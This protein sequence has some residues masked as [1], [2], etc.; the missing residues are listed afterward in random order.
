MIKGK[1]KYLNL[2]LLLNIIFSNNIN[3]MERNIS[4]PE[5][6]NSDFG[7][8]D[9]PEEMLLRIM[10]SVIESYIDKLDDI[11]NLDKFDKSKLIEDIKNFCLACK[12]FNVYKLDIIRMAKNAKVKK[13]QDLADPIK[14]K[15]FGISKEGLNSQLILILNR[16]DLDINRIFVKYDLME[17]VSLIISGA[18]VNAKSDL[19]NTA[20]IMAASYT[21]GIDEYMLYDYRYG[22]TGI[23]ELLLLLGA[24]IN[25]QNNIGITP[26]MR[27]ISQGNRN[28]V[29]YLLNANPIIN[30]KD[31]YGFS[32]FTYSYLGDHR[33]ID[34]IR[35]LMFKDVKNNIKDLLKFISTMQ[36]ETRLF[37][38]IFAL[39]IVSNLYFNS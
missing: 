36:F 30:I 29:E 10:E 14:A 31:A 33:D 38:T 32:A 18:D 24:D 27:A 26:L 3:A 23:V 37:L 39:L 1:I 11:F 9:M 6:I 21:D 22:H 20:L 34:I 13:F 16:L 5:N 17:A 35:L 7:I 4:E 8:L 12:A 15:Y 25:T 2:L 19:G 28:V